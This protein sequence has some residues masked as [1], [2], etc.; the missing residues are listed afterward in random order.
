LRSDPEL[1]GERGATAIIGEVVRITGRHGA[2]SRVILDD[3][4]EGWLESATLVSLDATN[5]AEMG[6]D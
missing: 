2:W 3:G 6:G 4:R 5:S 1:G